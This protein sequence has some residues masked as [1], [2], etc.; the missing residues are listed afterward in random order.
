VKASVEARQV[1]RSHGREHCR[2]QKRAGTLGNC[3]RKSNDII[4]KFAAYPFSTDRV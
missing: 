4:A 1:Y 2:K 3:R